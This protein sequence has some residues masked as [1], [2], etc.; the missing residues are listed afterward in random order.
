MLL[1]AAGSLAARIATVL[2]ALAITLPYWLRRAGSKEMREAR[3]VPYLRRLWP[4][5]WAGYSLLGLSFFHAGTV[6]RA[7]GLADLRGIWAATAALLLMFLEVFLGLS[8]RAR[9]RGGPVSGVHF[10]DRVQVIEIHEQGLTGKSFD[11]RFPL[12]STGKFR[13]P[14]LLHNLGR[15]LCCGER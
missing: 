10:F 8:L 9:G 4:H 12:A 5:F 13:R 1:Y 15:F 11:L 2:C 3:R 6:M 14:Q 7:M